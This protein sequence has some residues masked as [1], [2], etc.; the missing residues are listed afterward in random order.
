[1][2]ELDYYDDCPIQR[3]ASELENND[4]RFSILVLGIVKSYPF[5]NRKNSTENP[6]GQSP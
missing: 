1:G 5:L 6:L 2:R 3:I 4:N